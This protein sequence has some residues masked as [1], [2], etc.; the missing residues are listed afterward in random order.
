MIAALALVLGL[1]A[2]APTGAAA[3]PLPGAEQVLAPVVDG[4][5]ESEAPVADISDGPVPVLVGAAVGGPR[6]AFSLVVTNGPRDQKNVALTFD[7]NF[8]TEVALRTLAALRQ[9]GAPATAFV[10]GQGVDLEPAIVEEI[11]RNPQLE[12]GDHS[13]FHVD[14]TVRD[15]PFIEQAI[16]GGVAA[17]RQ[18]TAGHAVSLFRPPGG[19][20]NA[21]VL[22]TAAANGF[23]TTVLWDCSP[24]D[25]LGIDAQTIVTR[26]MA[27]LKPGSIVLLHLNAPHTAEALPSLIQ[28]IRAAGYR[29]VTVSQLLKGGRRFCDVSP[30]DPAYSAVMAIDRSGLLRGYPA[31]DFG[32]TEGLSRRNLARALVV[33]L[34]LHTLEVE[35][36]DRPTFADV[37]PPPGGVTANSGS[38]DL[39]RF[40]YIEEAVA[41]GLMQGAP[42]AAGQMLFRPTA[43]V[44][45]IDL[46]LAIARVAAD[47]GL[48]PREPTR[49]FVDTPPQAAGAVAAI[50]EAGLMDPAGD[51]FG[52]WEPE[53]RAHAARVLERLFAKIKAATGG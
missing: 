37:V 20:L 8:G 39:A 34:G 31:G 15:V 26:T 40:D 48:L 30:N 36:Y 43:T 42:D 46:A 47:A 14:L 23:P 27:T 17:Y 6:P 19:S 29:L 28:A 7:D 4:S 25:F 5:V 24:G 51:A 22:K 45:R 33:G 44:R 13:R 50:A 53:S 2:T 16:G 3:E 11:A 12:V 32:A 9:A 10:V 18:A 52:P 38:Q 49:S 35:A 1:A 41:H 21:T